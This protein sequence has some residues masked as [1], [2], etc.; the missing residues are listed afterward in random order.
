LSTYAIGDVQGCFDTLQAL[1]KRV[2]FDP[3]RDR[4]WLAGDLV[5]RGPK[6]LEVLRWARAHEGAVTAVLGNHDLH[7]LAVA[8]GARGK[9]HRDT[10]DEVLGAPDAGDLL[11]WLRRRPLLHREGGR[12]M[13]HAG[14]HRDWS[15]DD[16]ATLAAEVEDAL[17]GRHWA[18]EVA[19]LFD[20]PG[21]WG[22]SL[23]GRE[24]RAS[25]A[26]VLT[27]IRVCDARGVPDREFKAGPDAIPPGLYPWFDVPGRRS[28]DVTVLFGHWAA[29]GFLRRPGLLGLDTGCVWGDRLTAVRLE[30]DAVFD[31]PALEARSPD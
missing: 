21:P 26:A 9:K 17:R 24:R 2:A 30:D 23:R 7:L 19:A 14:L 20:R 25:V 22:P 4:V 15:A 16:A 18:R 12:V 31:Q 5:N 1:L 28:A 11:D 8:A 27:T 6:S 13:V 3:A 10:I 29:L